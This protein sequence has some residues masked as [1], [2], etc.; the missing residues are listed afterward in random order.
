MP[1]IPESTKTSL[2]QRLRTHA[3]ARWPQLADVRVRYRGRFAYVDGELPDGQL[4]P[5]MR[6]RYGGSATRWGFALYQASNN[7]Y[8]DS[9]LPTGTHAGG[10]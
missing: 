4:L 9:A 3:R 7:G 5:L 6:L 1:A 10:P 8:H 2:A